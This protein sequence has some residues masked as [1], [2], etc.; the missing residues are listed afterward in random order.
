VKKKTGMT[1]T[2][3]LPQFNLPLLSI[4]GKIGRGWM[5][6]NDEGL[7]KICLSNKFVPNDMPYSNYPFK[8]RKLDM[9]HAGALP[10]YL[11]RPSHS[12][13]R[14]AKECTDRKKKK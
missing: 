8:K 13:P 14:K 1:H 6:D 4:R 12:R 11:A 5:G 9:T 2:G 10:H 3:A 7:V